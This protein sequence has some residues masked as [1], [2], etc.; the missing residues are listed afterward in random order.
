MLADDA[1]RR[2]THQ[3]GNIAGF[4]RRT[5]AFI[6]DIGLLI[7]IGLAVGYLLFPYLAEIGQWGHLV[8]FLIALGYFGNFDSRE[9][10]GQTL[11]KRIFRIRVV[12][13]DGNPIGLSKAMVRAAISLAPIFLYNTTI[14]LSH[15]LFFGYFLLGALSTTLIVVSAYL[16]IFNYA[17][18]QSIHDFLTGA[19]V[20]DGPGPPTTSR[21]VWR[22]H[23]TVAAFVAVS[24]LMAFGAVTVLLTPM[25]ARYEPLIVDVRALPEVR[26]AGFSAVTGYQIS[27]P[28][29]H[30][31]PAGRSLTVIANV[32]EPIAD[33]RPLAYRIAQ[34]VL[35]QKPELIGDSTVIIQIA[36]GYDLGIAHWSSSRAVAMPPEKWADWISK[37]P[38]FGQ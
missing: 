27:G 7:G 6:I 2:E 35:R 33:L 19:Y 20:V 15:N 14:N 5:G 17:T 31:W 1:Q 16:Y 11:G 36:W 9:H 38:E 18:H 3:A 32:K 26:D 10:D 8:G 28:P 12:G 24:V 23:L 30:E 4:W 37:H 34:I 22:P 29:S 21:P 13:A 25:F